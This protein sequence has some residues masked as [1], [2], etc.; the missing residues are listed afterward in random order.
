MNA[1][2]KEVTHPWKK[3]LAYSRLIYRSAHSL[4]DSAPEA[5]DL[6][7]EGFIIAYRCAQIWEPERGAFSTYLT[8]ALKYRLPVELNDLRSPVVMPQKS[9]QAARMVSAAEG[10]LSRKLGRS[11]TD[12]EVF[13]AVDIDPALYRAIRTPAVPM[14]APIAE[15]GGTR[16]ALIGEGG[17][18]A[19]VS[20]IDLRRMV[21]EI[22][23]F[24][25]TLDPENR[26][27]WRRVMS[28]DADYTQTEAARIKGVT[29][30]AIYMRVSR[31]RGLLKE[32]LE[33]K[34]LWVTKTG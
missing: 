2:S 30:Q 20:K 21:D 32:T 7:Q 33:S 11:P 34:G 16:H 22:D 4:T 6:A 27:V 9:A 23:A 17:E 14:D 28:I 10:A 12:A 13:G 19:I 25:D 29:R 31:L 1:R 18:D 24:A 8:R 5:E 26:W 3:V 15:D